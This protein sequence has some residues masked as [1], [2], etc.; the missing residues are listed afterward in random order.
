MTRA[1]PLFGDIAPRLRVQCSL[2]RRPDLSC[3]KPLCV[4]ALVL[5][6]LAAAS[7]A[8][9]G[10]DTERVRAYFAR[11]LAECAAWYTMVAEAPGLDAVTQIRF[12]AVGTSL[13]STAADIA[14][15]KWA[16][17][18]MELATATIRRE[19]RDSW[20]NYSVVDKKY[21][22]RCREVATDPA[23]R[24]QYWLNKHD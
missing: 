17:T 3:A 23:A 8:A 15:E 12:R 21:G 22:Q 1:N 7:H 11:E 18:Q 16:L 4:R 10:Y 24:R 19:M 5:V 9:S 13:L 20:N 2:L 6:A 14:T